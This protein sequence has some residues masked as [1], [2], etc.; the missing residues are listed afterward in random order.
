[1][2]K[3]INFDNLEGIIRFITE[4]AYIE[5]SNKFWFLNK[6]NRINLMN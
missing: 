5:I 6:I 3:I 4:I 2:K 1:M